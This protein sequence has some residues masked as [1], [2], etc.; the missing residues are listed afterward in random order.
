MG[1]PC[2]NSSNFAVCLKF[3]IT[4]LGAEGL[5]WGCSASTGRVTLS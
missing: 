3:F 5:G 1:I 2:K 4:K